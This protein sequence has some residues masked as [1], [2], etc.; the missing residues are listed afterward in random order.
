MVHLS[1]FKC[2]DCGLFTYSI[3]SSMKGQT[4]FCRRCGKTLS[5]RCTENENEYL[6]KGYKAFSTPEN[7][8]QYL[9]TNGCP[10]EDF[11]KLLSNPTADS[12]NEIVSTKATQFSIRFC[13]KCGKHFYHLGSVKV[14]PEGHLIDINV[15]VKNR[16]IKE[17]DAMR[18][19]MRLNREIKTSRNIQT[20][21]NEIA[22]D[23][24]THSILFDGHLYSQDE[25][26]DFHERVYR[27]WSIKK[28]FTSTK[29]GNI[30]FTRAYLAYLNGFPDGSDYKRIYNTRRQILSNLSQISDWDQRFYFYLHRYKLI[31]ENAPLCWR[32]GN[33][34]VCYENVDRFVTCFLGRDI[35]NLTHDQM[36][37]MIN[38]QTKKYF[39]FPQNDSVDD[40]GEL[41]DLRFTSLIMSHTSEQ[42]LLYKD[43]NYPSLKAFIRKMNAFD[44]KICEK[45]DFI[46]TLLRHKFEGDV[47]FLISK[48][49]N[50]AP[51]EIIEPDFS[52]LENIRLTDGD[53]YYLP[54]LG[55]L[56][57][58][59][60]YLALCYYHCAN[61]AGTLNVFQTD[62]GSDCYGLI[63]SI[64][65]IIEDAYKSQN[66][67]TYV[68][69][70]AVLRLA[71]LSGI[72][73]AIDGVSLELS[74]NQS[75][76]GQINQF[77]NNESYNADGSEGSFEKLLSKAYILTLNASERNQAPFV[78]DGISRSLREHIL[79]MSDNIDNLKRFWNSNEVQNFVNY[80]L[81]GSCDSTGYQSR[82]QIQEAIDD[83]YRQCSDIETR[84]N[85]KLEEINSKYVKTSSVAE[86]AEILVQEPEQSR[87]TTKNKRTTSKKTTAP[88]ETTSN[89]DD[90]DW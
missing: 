40:E 89:N 72:V 79:A 37:L 4:A 8:I 62:L 14:C 44:D 16:F 61:N 75:L 30:G 7:A 21:D 77:F 33:K 69:K 86:S 73:E 31:G 19:C 85:K 20:P 28:I 84:L 22:E 76:I 27:T 90:S 87:S 12:S 83:V 50:R 41:N 36:Q 45:Y 39:F 64:K 48:I 9:I 38:A 49:F 11:Q 5:I 42:K 34:C 13:D 67:K 17:I 81:N 78:Y 26:L 71:F 53:K 82:D 10:E 58:L 15:P 66:S 47:E 55:D 59:T 74:N 65:T 32:I 46:Q 6:P 24:L 3:A 51:F 18:E 1:V 57:K 2:I 23:E 56:K 35:Y 54:E 25:I 68:R 88:V 29:E 70:F 60:P 52:N 80:V 43:L 63:A